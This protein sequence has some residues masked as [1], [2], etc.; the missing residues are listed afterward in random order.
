MPGRVWY[1]VAGVIGAMAL[2][3]FV[4]ILLNGIAGMGDAL[5]QMLG[6]GQI[7]ITLEE[8]GTYTVFHEHE[9]IFEGQYY[10]S[11]E[12][13]SGLTVRVR[14]L[15]SS[16]AIRVEAPNVSTNYAVSGRSGVGIFE[17]NIVEPG[18]YRITAAYG[19]GQA[20]PPVVLAIGHD[21]MGGLL[22]TIFGAIGVMMVGAGL[23]ISIVVVTFVKR[24]KALRALQGG[25]K[26]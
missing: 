6:P 19:N 13:V 21:F 7:E 18:R 17:F 16:D 15:D 23:V 10:S 9:S 14:S 25:A 1:W 5:Q 22:A 11:P 8:P 20:T 26:T 12:I 2:T 24:E 3:A 4:A